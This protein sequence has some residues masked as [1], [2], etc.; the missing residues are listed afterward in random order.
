MASPIGT[1]WTAEQ[2]RALQDEE[3]AWPR[4]ELVDGVLLVTNAPRPVHQLMVASLFRALDAYVRTHGLGTF[5]L[6]PS[7]LELEPGTVVQPDLFVVP[8]AFGRVR[9]WSD[10][11]GL[12]L[13]IE[14]VSPSSA[15]TDRT[16]KR[17][18]HQRA[19]VPDYWVVDVDARLVERWTPSDLRPEPLDERLTWH[20]AGAPEP[21]ALDLPALFAEA[22]GDD[23]PR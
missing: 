13:A 19:G 20:P 3:R 5:F 8:A 11:R 10:A 23:D 16:R 14:I 9:D 6:S 17:R 12:L 2:V 4:Y 1:G 22:T 15:N 7:A 21:L 18:L